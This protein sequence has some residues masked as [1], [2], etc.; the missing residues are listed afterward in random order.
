MEYFV[1]ILYSDSLKRFYIGQTN[2]VRQRFKRHNSG[3][4]KYTS[5]GVPWELVWFTSK[6]SRSDA[7]ILEKKLKNL[8]QLRL[9]RFMQKYADEIQNIQIIEMLEKKL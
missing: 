4:E 5:K 7:M 6:E 1:Y 8:K 9:L 2:D 3:T